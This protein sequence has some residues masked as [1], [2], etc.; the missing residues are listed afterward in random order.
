MNPCIFL[1]H[2]STDKEIADML[3]DFLVGVGIPNELIFCSSLPGNDVVQRIALEVKSTFKTVLLIFVSSLT[4]TMR[5]HI[6]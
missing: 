6:V 1:S 2:R 3:R 4:T 5:A